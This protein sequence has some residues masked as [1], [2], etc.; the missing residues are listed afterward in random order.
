LH[1]NDFVFEILRQPNTV[2][3]SREPGT[4]HQWEIRGMLVDFEW[5]G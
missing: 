4:G 3:V 1:E 5:A 2:V